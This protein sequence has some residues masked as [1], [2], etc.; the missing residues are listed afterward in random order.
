LIPLSVD[1]SVLIKWIHPEGEEELGAARAV[2]QAHMA[3]R[4]RVHIL[5]LTIYE[6]GNVM[7]R[8]LNRSTRET[9]DRLDDLLA[10]CGPP[11]I[12]A[13]A[14]RRDAAELAQKYQLTFYDAAFAAAARGL[15]LSLLSADRR[16]LA[17]G[18][19]ETVT[20]W[21]NRMRL[22]DPSQGR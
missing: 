17:A 11:Y 8:K 16:L 1:S 10:L 15:R 19:A 22:E 6:L 18:L 4:V 13:A 21:V 3:E 14:W 5:D 2:R 7:I 12:L 20:D 9:A